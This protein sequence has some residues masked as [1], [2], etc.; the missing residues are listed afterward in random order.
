VAPNTHA[1]VLLRGAGPCPAPRGP[2]PRGPAHRPT[3]APG[4]EWPGRWK[5]SDRR[6][7]CPIVQKEWDF[8]PAAA[9]LS[10]MGGTGG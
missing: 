1:R 8:G 3:S 9:K 7:V 5:W 4:A 2:A 10:A 6:N